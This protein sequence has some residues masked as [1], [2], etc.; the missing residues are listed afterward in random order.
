MNISVYCYEAV[1]Y[2]GI[3]TAKNTLA[4]K[5]WGIHRKKMPIIKDMIYSDRMATI[6]IIAPTLFAFNFFI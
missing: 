3:I 2:L 4:M 5:S 1:D 6:P